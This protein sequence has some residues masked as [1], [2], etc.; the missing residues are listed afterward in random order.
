MKSGWRVEHTYLQNV[1][2]LLT[3][4]PR[5]TVLIDGVKLY[6]GFMGMKTALKS[7]NG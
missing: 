5:H 7:E 3:R 2:T 6:G 4:V 1:L